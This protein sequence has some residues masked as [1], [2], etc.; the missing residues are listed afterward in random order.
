LK[1]GWLT[2]GEKVKE[3]EEKFV[4]K[5]GYKYAVAVNSATSG[6]LLALQT[7]GIPKGSTIITSVYTFAAT[8]H[9]IEQLGFK[10]KFV[11][12][13]SDSYLIDP[14]ELENIITDDVKAIL[15]V[16]LA[17]YYTAFNWVQIF[18]KY[19]EMN[20]I[21]DSAHSM[22]GYKGE[23]YDYYSPRV[24]S[25]YANKNL[26]IG[27]GGMIC[28]NDENQ[29]KQIR[30]LMNHGI[31][32]DVYSRF[33]NDTSKKWQYDIV[34]SGY[35]YNL[36][37]LLAAIGLEQLKLV[38]EIRKK[39][40]DVS[41]WYSEFLDLNKIIFCYPIYSY[42]HHDMHL[43]LV[44]VPEDKRD[45]IIQELSKA[46][47]E[48]SVHY[49]PLHMMSYF[50]NKYGFK[51]EDFPNAYHNYLQTISLPIY[52]DLKKSEVKYICEKLNSLL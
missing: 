11:D 26:S 16:D 21:H 49:K 17:G 40:F 31:D 43:L 30:I 52:P 45:Y 6:L 9:V 10:L 15:N 29:V 20:L 38:D 2:T 27:E 12:I 23:L 14:D 33:T 51:D 39:R 4:A 7:S 48:T 22:P 8:A 34:E 28:T 42:Y 18:N 1:S 41:C 3:F 47:I 35:K 24:Y 36:P 46:G 50:K 32:R 5:A 25:F 13:K 44:R 37:D 19:P